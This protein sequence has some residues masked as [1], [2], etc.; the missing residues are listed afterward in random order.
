MVRLALWHASS[1]SYRHYSHFPNSSSP[2]DA[3]C[4]ES[5]KAMDDM[6]LSL[7]VISTFKE[8][9][10]LSR[11][12]VKKARSTKNWKAERE[13]LEDEFKA[14]VIILRCIYR[15]FL[16]NNGLVDDEQLK[17][18]CYTD[19]IRYTHRQP[20]QNCAYIST[21]TTLSHTPTRRSTQDIVW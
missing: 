16:Q 10:L 2:P 19:I 7:Q 4:P 17:E 3:Q 13:N 6:S 1:A 12:I 18:V 5:Q 9:Y 20:A 8:L 14:E 21:D 15:V 11:F